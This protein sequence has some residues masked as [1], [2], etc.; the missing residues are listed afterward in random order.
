MKRKPI[1][2]IVE[3]TVYRSKKNPKYGHAIGLVLPCNHNQYLGICRFPKDLPPDIKRTRVM[4]V[5]IWEPTDISVGDKQLCCN[6]PDESWLKDMPH[7]GDLNTFGEIEDAE[8]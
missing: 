4:D 5:R 8:D 7:V 1:S 6:C 3:I 2:R